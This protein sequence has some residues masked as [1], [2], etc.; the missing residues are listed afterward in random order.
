MV[1]NPPTLYMGQPSIGFF[2][3]LRIIII[4]KG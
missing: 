3:P 1:G 4:N 2:P